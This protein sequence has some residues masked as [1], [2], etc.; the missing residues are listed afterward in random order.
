MA[1]VFLGKGVCARARNDCS[2]TGA[3]DCPP[4]KVSQTPL[5]AVK[6]LQA[7]ASSGKLLLSAGGE[8]AGVSAESATM[9]AA[10]VALAGVVIVQFVTLVTQHV[11]NRRL[12]REESLRMLRWAAEL[13]VQGGS[14]AVES[15]ADLGVAVLKALGESSLIRPDDQKIVSAA[16]DSAVQAG[17]D[18]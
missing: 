13:A 1:Q 4:I 15:Q 9:G 2:V 10:F 11:S 5:F 6:A 14:P 3:A 16:L 17:E 12:Q 8:G 7:E 18:W